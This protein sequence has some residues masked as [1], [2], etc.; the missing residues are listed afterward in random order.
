M[1]QTSP[2]LQIFQPSVLPRQCAKAF[3]SADMLPPSPEAHQEFCFFP[4]GERYTVQ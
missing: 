1:P 3:P 2:Q 4:N